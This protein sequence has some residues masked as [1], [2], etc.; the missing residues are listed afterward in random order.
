MIRDESSGYGWGNGMMFVKG[1]AGA[2]MGKL[3]VQLITGA[4]ETL[5]QPIDDEDHDG[6]WISMP[7]GKYISCK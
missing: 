3:L 4:M 1:N 5:P 2:S 7:K 6:G